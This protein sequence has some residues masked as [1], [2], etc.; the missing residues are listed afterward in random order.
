MKK[1]IRHLIQAYK[2][3]NHLSVL[4]DPKGLQPNKWYYVTIHVLVDA[5]GNQHYDNLSLMQEGISN[6]TLNKKAL[7]TK[8]IKK[9]SHPKPKNRV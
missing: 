7:K 5:K 3:R 4:I 6:V 8:D 1:I 2:T 9:L